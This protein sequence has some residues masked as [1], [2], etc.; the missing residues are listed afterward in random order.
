MIVETVK[1]LIEERKALDVDDD[2]RLEAIWKRE[3]TI[4]AENISETIHFINHIC[5]DETFYWLSEVFDDVVRATQS[6]EFVEAIRRR[7]EDVS[8]PKYK[9]DIIMDLS[10]AEKEIEN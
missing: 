3:S 7:L 1:A 8:D 4:L 6:R 2:D 9:D 5:D 10:F